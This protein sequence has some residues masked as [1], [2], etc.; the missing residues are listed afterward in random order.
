MAW[1]TAGVGRMNHYFTFGI[2]ACGK[3]MLH[4]GGQKPP[5]DN[6]PQCSVCLSVLDKDTRYTPTKK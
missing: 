1:G 3:Y 5:R 4:S 6:Y 2:S